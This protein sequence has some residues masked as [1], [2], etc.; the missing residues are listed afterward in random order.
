MGGIIAARC[1]E[2]YADLLRA[3]SETE[4]ISR[5]P[6]TSRRSNNVRTLNS[7]TD[8]VITIVGALCLIFFPAITTTMKGPDE[9]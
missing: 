9:E 8:P 7:L 6:R 2:L 4:N 1:P 3:Q 5:Y